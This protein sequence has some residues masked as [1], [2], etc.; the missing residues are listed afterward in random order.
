MDKKKKTNKKIRVLI[1]C[2]M[3]VALSTALSFA[4][5]LQMP[6]GG[7]VTLLSMLPVSLIAIR[8]GTGIGLGSA[9][10]YGCLQMLVSGAAGWG[11]TPAVFVMCLLFDYII[12]YSVLGFSG[13]FKRFGLYGKLSGI[14]LVCILRFLCH[15]IT[16]VTIWASSMPDEFI[17]QFGASPYLYSLFYNGTYMGV[18]LVLTV[19]GAFFVLKAFT[20]RNIA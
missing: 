8:H 4:K 17:A 2:A 20:K 1:E 19:V 7:S 10:V 3:L 18:E 13:L 6:F 16:G 11:L 5:I 12:A 14:A 9:F 15:F